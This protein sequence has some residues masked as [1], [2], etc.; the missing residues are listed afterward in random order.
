MAKVPAT[1]KPGRNAPC[2][3]GSGLKYKRCCGRTT[4]QAGSP[5]RG[6]LQPDVDTLLERARFLQHSGQLPEAARAVAQILA[7]NPRHGTALHMLGL[8]T[9]ERGNSQ[10]ALGLLA[11]AVSVAPSEPVFRNNYGELL[12]LS[13]EYVDALAQFDKALFLL[14]HYESAAN[15]KAL[16]LLALGRHREAVAVLKGALAHHPAS[17]TLHDNLGY[18]LQA[19]GD[20]GSA[21][22]HHQKALAI[23]PDMVSARVNLGSAYQHQARFSDAVASYQAA[24]EVSA[25]TSPALH[26]LGIC[27][28]ELGDVEQAIGYLEQALGI[29]PGNADLLGDYVFA[30]HHLSP[31]FTPELLALS[32]RWARLFR[33]TKPVQGL[34]ALRAGTRRPGISIGYLSPFALASTTYFSEAVITRH[35]ADF[36]VYYYATSPDAD[37]KQPWSEV[38]R[39]Q[40]RDISLLSDE[41]ANQRIRKDKIDIL[42]DLAGNVRGHRLR[43]LTHK[44]APVIITWTESF[45]TTGCE[46]VD[47]FLSDHCS[48][49]PD[50]QRW[51]SERLAELPHY[52]FCYAPPPYAP[53]VGPPP[54][55]TTGYVTFGCF[56][57]AA[58][59]TR[60]VIAVWARIL[61]RLS[62]ARL[63]LKWKSYGEA[64][65]RDRIVG[66]F[67]QHG[68]SA[69][70][71]ELRSHSDHRTM[72]EQYNDLDI[73]LDT[74]P[75]NGG[76]TTC[77]A[78]WMGVPVVCLLGNTVVARQSACMLKAMGCE[79]TI[80]HSLDAY[81]DRAV[82]LA[83]DINA[84]SAL[85]AGLRESMRQSPLCD[86]GS[87]VEDLES[88]YRGIWQK[89]CSQ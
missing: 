35:S 52:R 33:P 10:Q 77:E 29:E 85:R 70:R 69:D 75:Q 12:R 87:F 58:K 32:K 31:S 39:S 46:Q 30:R 74:F 42:I 56:T 34:S 19:R 49:L 44:P 81:V 73:A 78:I 16:A 14:P 68:V 18:A 84:L 51:F 1:G 66:L 55:Q 20:F 4:G 88:V 76:L 23:A 13:G 80:A 3:C 2:P 15:N 59:I 9:H 17:A 79:D 21:V 48:S 54:K 45:Y 53:E 71:I 7:A 11:R 22:E 83:E 72:L 60:E 27:Y 47:Y 41:K 65:A 86:A 67:H 62:D 36:N 26:N 64:T 28:Q 6:A 50:H 8:I 24:L 5:P 43:L 57:H 25:T 37:R 82:A 61:V 63:V 40:W 38:P 89:Q